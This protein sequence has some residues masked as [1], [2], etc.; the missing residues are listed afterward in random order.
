MSTLFPFGWM[1]LMPHLQWFSIFRH[2]KS[3]THK[4]S[5]PWRLMWHFTLQVWS[6]LCAL[7]R[8][9][10]LRPHLHRGGHHQLHRVRA[11]ELCQNENGKHKYWMTKV[12][13]NLVRLH[14][15]SERSVS[16]SRLLTRLTPSRRPLTTCLT[17]AG[18]WLMT[19][20]MRGPW[21]LSHAHLG[22]PCQQA[23]ILWAQEETKKKF[24]FGKCHFYPTNC[25]C[26][27]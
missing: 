17:P 2:S 8:Y 13:I 11:G 18:C 5:I 21:W 9:L 1:T 19:R 14:T 15:W 16:S 3:N 22:S 24:I 20:C 12:Y 26:E 7:P 25:G 10:S 6:T 23:P 4:K 27:N